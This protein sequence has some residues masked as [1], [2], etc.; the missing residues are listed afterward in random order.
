M[1]EIA[2]AF[3]SARRKAIAI[4]LSPVSACSS[5]PG[6]THVNG[7]LKRVKSSFLYFDVDAKINF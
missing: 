2:K 5:T 4:G 7:T 6:E 1:L 3:A